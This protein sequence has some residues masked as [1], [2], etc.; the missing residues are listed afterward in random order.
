MPTT[1]GGTPLNSPEN[2]RRGAEALEDSLTQLGVNP[3]ERPEEA[4]DDHYGPS[5]A[6]VLAAIVLKA[7]GG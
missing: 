1:S 6:E 7:V 4:E 3:H 5:T 2:I